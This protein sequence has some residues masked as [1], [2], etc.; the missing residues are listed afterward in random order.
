MIY[1]GFQIFSRTTGHSLPNPGIS[2]I[3]QCIYAFL[4]N[5]CSEVRIIFKRSIFS[6]ILVFL[7][8][9]FIFLSSF[10]G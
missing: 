8:V 1:G 10:F 6:F 4:K 9:S 3:P 5:N 2:G 7:S